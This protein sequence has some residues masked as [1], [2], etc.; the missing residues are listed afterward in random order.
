MNRAFVSYPRSSSRADALALYQQLGGD[1]GGL[2]F[3]D[4]SDIEYSDRFPERII[5]ALLGAELLVVFGDATYFTRWYCLLELRAG[6]APYYHALAHSV[7]GSG[8]LT[9]ALDGVLIVPTRDARSARR[10]AASAGTPGCQPSL[11]R[12]G[13]RTRGGDPSPS[14]TSRPNAR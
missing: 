6:L 10:M 4:T 7:R 2:A 14:R 3:L 13:G 12:S 8:L 11:S 1:T 5:D 9:N